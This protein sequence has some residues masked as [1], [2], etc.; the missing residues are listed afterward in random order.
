MQKAYSISH[1][2][3]AFLKWIE[4]PTIYRQISISVMRKYTWITRH[5]YSEGNHVR[6]S[7]RQTQR[8]T[9]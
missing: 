5:V 4:N 7:E 3:P 1:V 2:L 9:N 6:Q 8:L